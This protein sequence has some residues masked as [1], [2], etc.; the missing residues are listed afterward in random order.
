MPMPYV[1]GDPPHVISGPL[2]NLLALL[3]KARKYAKQLGC[4]VWQFAEEIGRLRAVGASHGDL[5]WLLHK[6]LIAHAEEI[7][8]PR[9]PRRVFRRLGSLMLNERACFV[10][11]ELGENLAHQWVGAP[12]ATD[13]SGKIL[14]F[15]EPNVIQPVWD[16]S[17]REL[18]VEAVVIK[19]YRCPAPNQELVLEAF[20][21]ERWPVRMD[22]PLPRLPGRDRK[23]RLHDTINHLNRNQVHRSLHFYG[24]GTGSGICWTLR[25]E[26]P[27]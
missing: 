11:T 5:R 23:Q 7:S 8:R 15:T 6:G 27:Q 10:L 3:E 16:L 20:Q 19:R 13:S 26:P 22:D 21:E 12:G 17:R 4:E 1:R 25:N 9:A 18:R 2:Q 14:L 24:D